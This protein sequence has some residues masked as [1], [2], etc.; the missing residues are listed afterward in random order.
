MHGT[1]GDH[2]RQVVGG[3]H[4]AIA[5]EQDFKGSQTFTVI[6]FH[7]LELSESMHYLFKVY[8]ALELVVYVQS[9]VTVCQKSFS[10]MFGSLSKVIFRHVRQSVKGHFPPCSVALKFTVHVVHKGTQ[11]IWLIE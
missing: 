10:A 11:K 7:P 1:K 4:T 6:P 3:G 9:N 5:K 2:Y 8:V